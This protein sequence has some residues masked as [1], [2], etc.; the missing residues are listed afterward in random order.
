MATDT[1]VHYN[2]RQRMATISQLWQNG[3]QDQKKLMHLTKYSPRQMKRL[4]GIL[5]EEGRVERKKYHRKPKLSGETLNSV[6][7]WLEENPDL[8]LKRIKEKLM[9]DHKIDVSVST[10]RLSLKK[11]GLKLQSKYSFPKKAPTRNA[12]LGTKRKK[13]EGN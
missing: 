2:Q 10:I 6:E 5:E 1:A 12:A 4:I 13:E 9:S 8:S 7:K 3:I 11:H